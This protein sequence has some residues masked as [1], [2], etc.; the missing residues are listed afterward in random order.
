MKLSSETLDILAGVRLI[1]TGAAVKGAVFKKG[2]KIKA[3]RYG[4]DMP[5]MY[6][7]IP[8]EI[9][10]DFAVHDLPKFLSMFSI[11]T[12]P[13][14]TFE[15]SYIIF[16]SGKK[17]AKFRYV[18]P[19]MIERDD[20]FFER[21]IKLPTVDF[22]CE[23]DKQTLKSITEAAAMFESP[24]IAFQGD[25]KTVTM[26]TYNVRDPKADKME[27]EVGESS[28]K[29]NLIMDLS[30]LQFLKRDYQVNV[31]LKGIVEWK[32]ADLKYFI[33]CSDKSKVE[34]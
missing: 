10:Q 1:N 5:V 25:G 9:P 18:A 29:F 12:D 19:R 7:D 22:S 17:K 15:D 23:I 34:Q 16:K 8:D 26:V 32:A 14:I 27:I 4:T 33:T 24:Q 28:H 3:R 2:N 30:V 20:T 13:E 11:L 21:E 31:C 6:A